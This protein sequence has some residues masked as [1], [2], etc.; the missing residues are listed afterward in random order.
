MNIEDRSVVAYNC[1]PVCVGSMAVE[2]DFYCLRLT[3]VA[4][5]KVEAVTGQ[6]HCGK[7]Q[8]C[9]ERHCLHRAEQT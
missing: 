5:P 7:I 8:M 1:F 6:T 9:T 3:D 4:E 2:V